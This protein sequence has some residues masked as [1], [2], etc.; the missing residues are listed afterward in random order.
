M[1]NIEPIILAANGSNRADT[2]FINGQIINVFTGEI[3]NMSVAVKDGYIC[4]LS[5]KSDEYD[6]DNIVD[7]N[8]LYLAPGFID[9]HLHI[10]S[11]MVTPAQFARGVVPCGTT[12]I[13]ADP[14][15]IA[16]VMGIKGI[17]YMIKSAQ[18]A[19][20]IMNILFT[21]PSCVPAT[22]MERAGAVIDSNMVQSLLSHDKIVGLAEMM[23]YPGVIF[24]DPQVMA[25]IK[26]AKM[27]KKQIDG[28]APKIT[29][30]ELN[31]YASA[32]IKSDHECTTFNEAI[33]K[34]RLGIHI[35]VREGSCAK[36]LDAL[37]PII[38]DKTWHQM[39]WC[40]DDRHP[41]EI[42]S[43]G[44]IDHIIRRAIDYGI[45]P[46]RAIQIAT[47]NPARY[48]KIDDVG[49]IAPSYRADMV[50]FRDI[51]NPVI[52]KVFVKGALVA[53]DREICNKI[54]CKPQSYDLPN[55]M[56]FDLDSVDFSIPIAQKL[57]PSEHQKDTI[58]RVIKIIPN[59]VVTEELRE[60]VLK[61]ESDK[62][63][64]GSIYAL[65]DTKRDILKIAVIERYSGKTG[66][67]RGF[68]NGFGFKK[69]AIASTVAHDSHN[70]IVAGVDDNDM[71]C[72]VKALKEMGG[73]FVVASGGNIMA[74]LALPVG[75]LM[76]N[77]PLESVNLSMVKVIEAVKALGSSKLS[78]PFMTLGFLALPV[79]PQLKI[80]DMGLVDVQ[81]FKIVELFL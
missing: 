43:E 17:E 29:G 3:L 44:H 12:T 54:E 15:E 62:A 60:S 72:A 50:A 32:G 47:I 71:L 20:D 79:I 57:N 80:T 24:T 16:N 23:N 34:L 70:V 26:A 45:D 2:L 37:L 65:S 48:F 28:H 51:K 36:N 40:T 19:G 11:S 4:G 1:I 10:E 58:A 27:A 78:D 63:E 74:R 67:A 38:N 25:K 14:H 9:P 35:M 69:G 41:E 61:S 77:E 21:A 56:N 42:L 6:A 76:S 81:K 39:M 66:M 68:V 53:Q 73:G 7:L 52:E 30:K 22:D 75:G 5:T 46:I 18:E 59:Q 31:A 55:T 13:V 33:E 64:D 49:A 8:G